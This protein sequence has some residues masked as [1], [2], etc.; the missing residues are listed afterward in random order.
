MNTEVSKIHT[1]LLRSTLLEEDSQSFWRNYNGESQEEAV[2][3]AYNDYWFGNANKATIKRTLGN[4]FERFVNFPQCLEVLKLWTDMTVQER[5]IICHW[6]VQMTDILYRRFTSEFL[7]SRFVYSPPTFHKDQAQQWVYGFMAEKWAGT[8]QAQMASKMLNC[9]RNTGL[10]SSENKETIQ[11]R[12][13]LISNRCVTYLL[14]T[15]R[16]IT[17]NGSLL[18][19][20]YFKSVGLTGSFLTS[21]VNQSPSISIQQTGD[22]TSFE[23]KHPSLIEWGQNE[24][25]GGL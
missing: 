25:N 11:L 6:H 18:E 7:P 20:P 16:E 12:Y 13:P 21:Q 15:L 10:V 22:H 24:F 4:L 2:E 1:R 3:K 14:Y 8:T 5:A 17:F 23:W 9:I 19:N